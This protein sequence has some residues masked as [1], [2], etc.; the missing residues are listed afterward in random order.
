MFSF[1]NLIN[2]V[3]VLTTKDDTKSSNILEFHIGASFISLLVSI[4]IVY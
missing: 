4:D 3:F 1:F 2:N